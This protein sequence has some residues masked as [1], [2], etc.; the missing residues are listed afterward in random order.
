MDMNTG[1]VYH[2]AKNSE[3]SDHLSIEKYDFMLNKFSRIQ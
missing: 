1:F 3:N 2:S